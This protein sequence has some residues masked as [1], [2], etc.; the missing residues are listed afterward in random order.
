MGINKQDKKQLE[1][2]YKEAY[3]RAYKDQKAS[4]L[5]KEI[6]R[7][8]RKAREDAKRDLQKHLKYDPKAKQTSDLGKK[9]KQHGKAFKKQAKKIQSAGDE[10]AGNLMGW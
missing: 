4:A 6:T 8:N 5:N 9:A 2:I 7:I 1:K 3:T 10:L